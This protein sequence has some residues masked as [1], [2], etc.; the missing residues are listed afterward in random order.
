VVVSLANIPEMKRVT[1]NE[2]IL[3]N[4]NVTVGASLTI[5]DLQAALKNVINSLEGRAATHS[6]QL[7]CNI[8]KVPFEH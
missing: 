4:G 5:S 3:K 1:T 7:Q 8:Y 2:M 6:F